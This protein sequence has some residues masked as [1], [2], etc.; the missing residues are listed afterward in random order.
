MPS[1]DGTGDAKQQAFGGLDLPT[2]SPAAG[3]RPQATAGMALTH[4]PV[5][6]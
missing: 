5:A 4:R 2:A 6:R 1:A 3:S